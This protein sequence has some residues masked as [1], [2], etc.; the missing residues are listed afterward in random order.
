M[1]LVNTE[2]LKSSGESLIGSS[3]IPGTTFHGKRAMAIIVDDVSQH[4]V[5]IKFHYIPVLEVPGQFLLRS[6]NQVIKHVNG[7]TLRRVATNPPTY[8]MCRGKHI[9]KETLR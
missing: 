7:F 2:D 3:P 6:C 5:P 8:Y 9:W 4:S 1:K